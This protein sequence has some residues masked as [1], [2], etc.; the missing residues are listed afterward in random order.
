MLSLTWE[1][2]HSLEMGMVIIELEM[3]IGVI[4]FDVMGC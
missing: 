3:S 4:C 1:L 2:R